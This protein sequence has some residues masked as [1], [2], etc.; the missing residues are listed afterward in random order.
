MNATVRC[1]ALEGHHEVIRAFL[2]VATTDHSDQQEVSEELVSERERSV[3][4]GGEGFEELAAMERRSH[5]RRRHQ[6]VGRAQN[7]AKQQQ[8][9][10]S[11]KR[12]DGGRFGS[13]ALHVFFLP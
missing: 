7:M 11:R 4:R 10:K 2:V 6:P 1:G 8:R 13:L 5:H 9:R 12:Q 3:N